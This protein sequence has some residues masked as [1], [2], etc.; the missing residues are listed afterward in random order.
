MVTKAGLGA[1]IAMALVALVAAA[2]AGP[3]WGHEQHKHAGSQPQAA[4]SDAAQTG[5][6][7][8]SAAEGAEPFPADIG[9]A[10]ELVDQTGKTVTDADFRGRYM[11]VFFGY[12]SCDGICPV[13]LKRMTRALDLLEEAGEQV[14]PIFI[15]VDPENDTPAAL[16]AYLPTIHA[17]LIGLT[18][19]PE[20]VHAAMKSYRV[21]ANPVGQSWKGTQLISHGSYIYLM[22]PDGALLTIMPPV[23]SPPA[24]AGIIQRY[25]GRS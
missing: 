13:S 3:A 18:G 5:A 8:D 11:L 1:G 6:A 12:A 14:Q 23:F 20:A 2:G 19:T 4:Q 9:G 24:M 17:R 25:L 15:T 22:G 7:P 16:A 10:F 21:N